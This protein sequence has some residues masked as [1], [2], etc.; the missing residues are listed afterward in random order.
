MTNQNSSEI[1]DTIITKHAIFSLNWNNTGNQIISGHNGGDIKFWSYPSKTLCQ[2]LKNF[3]RTAPTSL[4][5]HSKKEKILIGAKEEIILIDSKGKRISSRLCEDGGSRTHTTDFEKED[6]YFGV[7]TQNNIYI[8][9]SNCKLIYKKNNCTDSLTF[10][11]KKELIAYAYGI[12]TK[13]FNTFIASTNKIIISG[14][15]CEPQLEIENKGPTR[16]INCLLWSPNGEYLAV[17]AG[18]GTRECAGTVNIYD[19]GGNHK[20][21]ID[22]CCERYHTNAERKLAWTKDSKK[23]AAVEDQS[24]LIYDLKSELIKKINSKERINVIAIN[25]LE[26]ILACGTDQICW[27]PEYRDETSYINFYDL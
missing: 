18:G 14:Y 11:P 21:T 12:C 23:L 13:E 7:G 27:K 26:D 6:K 19:S 9:D 5:Y 17:H 22:I 1:K 4:T 20:K 2:E 16:T 25:P 3:T 10:H 24:I 15:D 8:F